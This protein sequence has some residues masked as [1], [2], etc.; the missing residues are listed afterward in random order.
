MDPYLALIGGVPTDED[1]QRALASKLRR[2]RNYGMLGMMT[3][4]KVI[5]PVGKQLFE[6]APEMAGDLGNTRLKDKYYDMMQGYYDAQAAKA[7]AD[8]QFK[9]DKLA[10]E[11]AEEEEIEYERLRQGE[12][13][14][15]VNGARTIDDLKRLRAELDR[16]D[17]DPGQFNVGGVPIPGARWAQNL[18]SQYG[19]SP[20]ESSEEVQKFWQ[21]LSRNYTLLERN[22][23]FGATL[24]T[25]E[26]QSWAG[27]NINP[28]MKKEQIKKGLDSLINELDTL[29]ERRVQGHYAE[30]IDPDAL[31]SYTGRDWQFPAPAGKGMPPAAAPNA[32]QPAGNDSLTIEIGGQGGPDTPV[33]EDAIPFAPK[34]SWVNHQDWMQLSPQE[35]IEVLRS[36]P[37]NELQELGVKPEFLEGM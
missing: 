9:Y 6:G 11:E 24:S 26:K 30:D 18:A 32:S 23:M 5:S 7:D 22:R 8:R 16:E 14:D 13:D 25:G 31:R 37:P 20:L 12:V 19:V 17:F 34:P 28:E 2:D 21:D 33:P 29:M 27:A 1:R 15:L 4:D 10:S 35:Q 3:G 36:L